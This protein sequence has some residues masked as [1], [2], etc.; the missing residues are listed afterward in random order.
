MKDVFKSLKR[1]LITFSLLTIILSILM[2]GE[3]YLA[4]FIIDRAE[5]NGMN[6]LVLI[7]IVLMFL[8]SQT[9]VYFFQQFKTA[10]LSKKSAFLFRK[11][12]SVNILD[13]F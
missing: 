2:V 6:Y 8:F 7:F 10:V 13:S 12:I 1:D 5:I 11:W 4:Q 3:A 9:V